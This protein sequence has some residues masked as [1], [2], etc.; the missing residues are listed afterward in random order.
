MPNESNDSPLIFDE[1]SERVWV[2][3]TIE[4]IKQGGL[5]H[6][7]GRRSAEESGGKQWW[8]RMICR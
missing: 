2:A 1:V 6:L 5:K 3:I 7:L 8:V 4:D